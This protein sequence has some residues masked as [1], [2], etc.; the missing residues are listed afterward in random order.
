M[1]Y[2]TNKKE[3]LLPREKML[4]YGS[5]SLFDHELLAIILNTGVRKG[6][7]KIDVHTL[8][9]IL[10][11]EY[12]MRGLF[13]LMKSPHEVIEQGLPPAKACQIAAISEIY[14]RMNSKDN[15]VINN[16]QDAFKYFAD[17][18]SL[19][20]E[21]VSIACLNAEN[22]VFY[23]ET[24]ALGKQNEAHCALIDVF[25]PPIRFY[26]QRIIVAHN[27]PDGKNE[28]SESDKKWHKNLVECAKK[29]EIDVLDHIIVTKT[30]F[31]SFAENGF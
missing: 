19:Q 7:E 14:R 23:R 10:L 17:M 16:P 29:L 25:H 22:M 5:K 15:G 9:K 8:S 4:Q 30:G 24:V 27:H 3:N 31:Y 6:K 12:G 20:R 1:K 18:Q 11:K 21:N 2:P 13:A 28:P 26:S